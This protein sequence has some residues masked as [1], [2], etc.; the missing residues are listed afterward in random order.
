M[1]H[2]GF[3]CSKVKASVLMMKFKYSVVKMNKRALA[4]LK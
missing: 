3:L 4:A 1:R 2:I